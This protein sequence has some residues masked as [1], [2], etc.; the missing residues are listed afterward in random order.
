MKAKTILNALKER[1]P[2]MLAHLKKIGDAWGTA[3]SSRKCSM[4]EFTAIK[5]I[6]IDYA[7]MEHAKNV[8]VIEA[9]VRL[10]RSGQ[11]ASRSR[12]WWGPTVR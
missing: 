9:A 11:L 7:V 4:R 3:R 10:G 2:E 8:A 12:G 6:S 5:G 1:Q